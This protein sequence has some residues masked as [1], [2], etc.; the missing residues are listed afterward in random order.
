MLQLHNNTPFTAGMALFPN[1]EAIDTLYVMVKATFN[2]SAQLTLADE[3]AP[4]HEADVYWTEPGKSSIKYAGDYHIG[5]PATDIIMLGHACVPGQHD[6]TRLDVSLA[7]GQVNKTVSVFGDRQ[8]KDGRITPPASFKTMPMVY[9]KAYGGF[10]VVNGEVA[11]ADERNPVGRGFAGS[12]KVEE[13]NGVPLPNLEDPTQLIHRPTDTPTPACFGA[14]APYWQ[15]RAG[16]AGT[17]DEQWQTGRAPYLPEDFDKRFCN[18]AHP[19]LVYPG[20]LQGGEPV[21]ITHMYPNG[22]LKFD[23]P[24]VSLLSRITLAGNE[25]TPGFNL[26]TL[27]LEPNQLRMS[28]VWRAAL[29]CDKQALKISDVR[30]ALRK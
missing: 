14:S 30:I 26:E 17:Y 11:E 8:W 24:R 16:Y 7:V 23:V 22:V 4:L 3:Q 13:M 5:K 2:M 21:Q 9:E 29:P 10:H 15:P 25:L 20:Y 6:A 27:V 12:R 28:L 1:E 19:D 18:A